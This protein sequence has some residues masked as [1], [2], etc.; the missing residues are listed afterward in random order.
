VHDSCLFDDLD[1]VP[2]GQ[3]EPDLPALF[4][5]AKVGQALNVLLV[6]RESVTV[7]HVRHTPLLD[8][9]HNYGYL[10]DLS[11]CRCIENAIGID[12]DM[13]DEDVWGSGAESVVHNVRIF[14]I[15]LIVVRKVDPR[16]R[17]FI[18]LA[19]DRS[20][21]IAPEVVRRKSIRFETGHNGKVA[22]ASLEHGPQIRV[23][24]GIGI[25]DIPNG[26]DDLKVCDI[27]AGQ[28]LKAHIVRVTCTYEEPLMPTLPSRPSTMTTR[29]TFSGVRG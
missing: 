12:N 7:G 22:G 28:F 5:S 29:E 13:S 24:F 20:S 27:V 3:Q 18:A 4:S 15:L 23:R 16:L 25:D 8:I 14:R 2:E 17:E 1:I 21:D 19:L 6:V 9:V 10:L 11:D 26:E